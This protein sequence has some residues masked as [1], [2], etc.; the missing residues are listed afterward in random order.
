M[1]RKNSRSAH[2]LYLAIETAT[3]VCSVLLAEERR[4]L[5]QDHLYAPRSQGRKLAPMI[6]GLFN[7]AQRTP[8]E[9]DYVAVSS[10]PGSYTGLRIGLST[11][12]GICVAL[13]KPLVAVDAL[14]A[15]AHHT[16]ITLEEEP[17]LMP[18]DKDF[19][20][21]PAID[22][23]RMEI[24]TALFDT[25]AL[26]LEP[27]RAEILEPNQFPWGGKHKGRPTCISGDGAQKLHQWAET[28]PHVHVLD[29]VGCHARGLIQPSL[30]RWQQGMTEDLVSFEPFYLKDFVA[31]KPGAKWNRIIHSG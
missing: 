6:Q 9:L 27:I 14:T 1:S 12:K 21:M 31:G 7:S 2:P 23:R 11:A 26:Q 17:S 29:Q 28:W 16:L 25:H 4:I 22:A 19:Q 13:D 3:D 30:H 18:P 20:I 15:L 24:F 5:A 10:G 8:E